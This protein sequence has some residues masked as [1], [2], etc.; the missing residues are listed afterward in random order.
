MYDALAVEVAKPTKQLPSEHLHCDHRYEHVRYC[1]CT[2]VVQASR[3]MDHMRQR[4]VVQR[5]NDVQVSVVWTIAIGVIV[6]ADPQNI[7]VISGAPQQLQFSILVPSVLINAFD[8]DDFIS[9][10]IRATID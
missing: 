7:G 5:G 1:I 2:G 6:I 4:L 10:Q 9:I 3:S 8:R